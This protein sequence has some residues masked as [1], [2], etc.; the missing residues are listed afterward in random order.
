MKK[1]FLTKL[2][3][4][5]ARLAADTFV[6]GLEKE[7]NFAQPLDALYKEMMRE[8]FFYGLG[9]GFAVAGQRVEKLVGKDKPFYARLRAIE[10]VLK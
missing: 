10:A 4:T 6:S 9:H 1:K 8:M 7:N 5:H 2:E 3:A